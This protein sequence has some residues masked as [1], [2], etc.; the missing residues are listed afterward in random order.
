MYRPRAVSD[1]NGFLS[2]CATYICHYVLQAFCW[3]G[4]VCPPGRLLI[5][6]VIGG[7]SRSWSTSSDQQQQPAGLHWSPEAV[8]SSHDAEVWGWWCEQM[9]SLCFCHCDQLIIIHRC[10][11]EAPFSKL[12]QLY[13]SDSVS[14]SVVPEIWAWFG[15]IAALTQRMLG[16]NINGGTV[17]GSK[18]SIK[19]LEIR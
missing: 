18:C 17:P 19:S 14:E 9:D 15:L 7:S 6:R 3:D 1:I 11:D 4:A 2:W 8:S 12:S 16:V 5:A 13:L 10:T